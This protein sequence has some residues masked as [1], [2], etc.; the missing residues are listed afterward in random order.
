MDV[1][2]LQLKKYFH[3]KLAEV[4]QSGTSSSVSFLTKEELLEL[5]SAW[6][7][8]TVWKQQNLNV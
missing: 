2:V 5:E 3:E 6:I 8:L 7:Q 1:R 4:K